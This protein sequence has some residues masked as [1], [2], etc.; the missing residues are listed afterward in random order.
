M[1]LIDKVVNASVK[2]PRD[3][4]FPFDLTDPWVSARIR[5]ITRSQRV[6]WRR[7]FKIPPQILLLFKNEG[8]PFFKHH[9]RCLYLRDFLEMLWAA[10]RASIFNTSQRELARNLYCRLV[11]SLKPEF[12]DKLWPKRYR[13]RFHTS[14]PEY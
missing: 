2:P 3:D 14:Y 9:G 8:V 7:H 12:K 5:S 13:G 1:C 4:E 10:S 6:Q 11:E